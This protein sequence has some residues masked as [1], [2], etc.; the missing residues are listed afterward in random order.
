[1]NISYEKIF[2]S[3]EIAAL[4][5]KNDYFIFGKTLIVYGVS[6]NIDSY[7]ATQ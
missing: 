2:S 4:S 6:R 1:M 5:Y 3:Y 7:R